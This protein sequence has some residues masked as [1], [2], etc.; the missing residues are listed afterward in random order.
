MSSG[1]DLWLRVRELE[2]HLANNRKVI[3]YWQGRHKFH[4]DRAEKLEKS[5]SIMHEDYEHLL[6]SI[7]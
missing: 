7:K 4:K 1:V 6:K 3:E 2:R 5:L